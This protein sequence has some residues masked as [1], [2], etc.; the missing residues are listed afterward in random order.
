MRRFNATA[1]EMGLANDR[2]AAAN[3]RAAQAG[4]ARVQ[5]QKQLSWRDLDAKQS[6]ALTAALKRYEEVLS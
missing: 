3:E 4:L 1:T 2:A 5:L 6:F